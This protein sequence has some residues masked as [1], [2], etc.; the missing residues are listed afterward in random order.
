MTENVLQTLTVQCKEYMMHQKTAEVLVVWDTED[1][2]GVMMEVELRGNGQIEYPAEEVHDE[3]QKK[4][5]ESKFRF[6]SYEGLGLGVATPG[7]GCKTAEV[8]VQK[9]S[10]MLVSKSESLVVDNMTYMVLHSLTAQ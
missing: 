7:P 5:G 4:K 10:E 1:R 6:K 8:F 3:L 2:S 9:T